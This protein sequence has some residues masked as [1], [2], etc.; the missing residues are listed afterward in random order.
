[1]DDFTIMKIASTDEQRFLVNL[2]EQSEERLLHGSFPWSIAVP[3]RKHFINDID[4]ANNLGSRRVNN[5]YGGLE[6][7]QTFIIRRK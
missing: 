4:S 6:I 7:G 1:M 3:M 5:G 2:F